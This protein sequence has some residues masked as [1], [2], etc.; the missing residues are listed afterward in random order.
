M[1][2]IRLFLVLTL[3]CLLL[4]IMVVPATAFIHITIP[5]DECAPEAAG[6]NPGNN[7]TARAAIVAAGLPPPL[8]NVTNA[9][10]D[11]PAP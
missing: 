8:G 2:K 10:T 1:K 5:A 3:V 4:T 7:P 6:D 9:P 11:C